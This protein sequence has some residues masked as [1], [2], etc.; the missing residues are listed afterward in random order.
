MQFRTTVYASKDPKPGRMRTETTPVAVFLC[1]T[2]LEGLPQLVNLLL[3]DMSML[4][5]DGRSPSFLE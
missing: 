2:R 4:G 1:Y 5:I 3:G